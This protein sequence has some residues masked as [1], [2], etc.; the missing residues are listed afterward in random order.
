FD[1]T[2]VVGVNFD[3]GQVPTTL[4][5]KISGETWTGTEFQHIGPKVE[6]LENPRHHLVAQLVLPVFGMA[7]PPV[8]KVH[9]GYRFA[10]VYAKAN[11]SPFRDRQFTTEHRSPASG[12]GLRAQ[13]L[14]PLFRV[15]PL[16]ARRGWQ[17]DL[18]HFLD[19]L[20]VMNVDVLQLFAG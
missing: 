17:G 9:G 10:T 7:N 11:A 15:Q 18:K 20:H 1:G 4:A 16:F 2:G 12:D 8:Q 14:F 3:G 13:N 5:E 6:P 19:R